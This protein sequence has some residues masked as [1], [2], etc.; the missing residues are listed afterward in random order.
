VTDLDLSSD[1]NIPSLTSSAVAEHQDASSEN[2]IDEM[3]D[4]IT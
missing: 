2:T 1:E 3:A 4:P